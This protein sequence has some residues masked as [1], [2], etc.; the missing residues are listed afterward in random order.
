MGGRYLCGGYLPHIV[1]CS[2]VNLHC[3]RCGIQR[4][5]TYPPPRGDYCVGGDRNTWSGRWWNTWRRKGAET[6]GRGCPTGGPRCVETLAPGTCFSSSRAMF[7]AISVWSSSSVSCDEGLRAVWSRRNPRLRLRGSH[8]WVRMEGTISHAGVVVSR[9]A[10]WDEL[11]REP[12]RREPG[13]W[14]TGAYLTG[15]WRSCGR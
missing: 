1:N 8:P 12:Q 3:A 9:P 11:A 5:L 13:R 10:F 4:S 6:Y 7:D 15:R 14:G 2:L